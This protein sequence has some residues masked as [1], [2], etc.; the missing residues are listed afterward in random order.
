MFQQ[1]ETSCEFQ[2]DEIMYNTLLDGCARQGLYDRGMALLEKMKKSGV[3]PSNFTL[4]VLVKLAN[5]GKKLEKAFEI[6]EEVSTKNNSNL[7]VHVFAN[8]IQACI[9]HRNLPR[10]LDVLVR[11]IEER[12]RPDVRSYSLLLRALIDARQASDVAGLLRAA[13]G[14]GGKHPWNGPR[15]RLAKFGANALKPQGCLP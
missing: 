12:T 9:N 15:T 4:S 3:R 11:M 10:A 1:L 14:T 6:C 7:N 8:L 5:R 13:T 2:P